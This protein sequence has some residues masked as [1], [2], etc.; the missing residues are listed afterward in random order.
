[1]P[2]PVLQKVQATTEAFYNQLHSYGSK[3]RTYANSLRGAG[4]NTAR[5]FVIFCQGRT[6]SRLL[7]DL[8]DKH[9]DIQC[10]QEILRIPRWNPFYFA[11][12]KRNRAQR[13]VLYGFK[14][15]IYQLRNQQNTAPSEFIHTLSDQ[16]WKVIYLWRQN[17]LR[18]SLS[19]HMAAAKNLWH[20]EEES[21]E[22]K[23]KVEEAVFID[24]DALLRDAYKRRVWLKE[25]RDI[26]KGI[27][28][29]EVNYENDLLTQDD[30][31]RTLPQLFDFLGVVPKVFQ[32]DTVRTSKKD[33]SKQIKNY[34]EVRSRIDSS[35][36]SHLLQ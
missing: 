14:V 17:V 36:F 28:F 20:A 6:G 9:P 10:D 21:E 16:R 30:R 29:F 34:E 33:L 26:L 32:P 11:L 5:G 25:E 7:C 1:M 8:L 27:N 35:E 24:P 12:G 22:Q 3:T 15:K 23:A 13:V 19:G 2:I 4:K 18:H 31:E